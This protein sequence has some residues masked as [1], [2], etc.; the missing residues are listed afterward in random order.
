MNNPWKEISLLDYENHMSL[1]SVNQNAEMRMV[2][3]DRAYKQQVFDFTKDC[4]EELGKSFEPDG[5][6]SFYNDIENN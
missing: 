5:R 4:F 6:H 1:A 3:Y 2:L